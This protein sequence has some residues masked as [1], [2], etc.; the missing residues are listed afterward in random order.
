MK[1]GYDASSDDEYTFDSDDSSFDNDDGDDDNSTVAEE[2]VH[3][4]RQMATAAVLAFA[5]S[6]DAR[7]DRPCL[8]GLSQLEDRNDA[9]TSRFFEYLPK[10]LQ[11]DPVA[12]ASMVSNV[13]PHGA[14]IATV[15]YNLKHAVEQ[16]DDTRTA[17]CLT[18]IFRH[19]VLLNMPMRRFVSGPMERSL[20]LE[21]TMHI[22]PFANPAALGMHQ[23]L[24]TTLVGICVRQVGLASP[25][26]LS[27][28]VDQWK[29]YERF[30]FH[31]PH[32]A[33]ARL[34][35]IGTTLCHSRKDASVAYAR[36]VFDDNAK[37]RD[38]RAQALKH[39]DV[40]A[41]YIP[42]ADQAYQ[43]RKML[44]NN[45]VYFTNRLRLR[46]YQAVCIG[47]PHPEY[48]CQGGVMARAQVIKLMDSLK[49]SLP[50]DAGPEALSVFQ[51]AEDIMLMM[52]AHVNNLHD[53]DAYETLQVDL[54]I[55]VYLLQRVLAGVPRASLQGPDS[56]MYTSR[57]MI[58][59]A[60]RYITS[61]FVQ[62]LWNATTD[63]ADLIRYGVCADPGI[64]KFKAPKKKGVT[65]ADLLDSFKPVIVSRH[66]E[67]LPPSIVRDDNNIVRESPASA[68]QRHPGTDS[69]QFLFGMYRLAS[70]WSKTKMAFQADADRVTVDRD[71]VDLRQG[72]K[73]LY[74]DASSGILAVEATL[75][76]HAVAQIQAMVKAGGGPQAKTN[77][78]TTTSSSETSNETLHTSDVS[79]ADILVDHLCRLDD[80]DSGKM[81]KAIMT[82]PFDPKDTPRLD[83]E[84]AWYHDMKTVL[85][86]EPD[87]AF[88][89]K[90]M[91][92]DLS[93]MVEGM[94]QVLGKVFAWVVYV[95]C[96]D[97]HHKTNTVVMTIE[98]LKHM[99][100]QD[101]YLGK[102]AKA[103]L[104]P[105]R[106]VRL[107]AVMKRTCDEHCSWK[108][109]DNYVAFNVT[110]K[111]ASIVMGNIRLIC[112][113]ETLLGKYPCSG[114]LSTL[115]SIRR[116][117]GKCRTDSL[118]AGANV[119]LARCENILNQS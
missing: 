61:A 93:A 37:M 66:Q 5:T 34:L 81:V 101:P 106:L 60:P 88:S 42:D 28:V 52:G 67:S 83:K 107:L 44:L 46:R 71:F 104:R 90:L 86:V 26:A 12:L 13:S 102:I 112:S 23:R 69:L 32:E 97:V 53:R 116:I 103:I 40:V 35:A 118:Y 95:P 74:R 3:R 41:T 77:A 25:C 94:G 2:E 31:L 43:A 47:M 6:D 15:E 117:V 29:A 62:R 54:Q 64:V 51:D 33:L 19:F 84:I 92:V 17:A 22:G 109:G 115:E 80:T 18:E 27:Y 114:D 58:A 10:R 113:T 70:M 89:T 98:E 87:V 59:A 14:T 78:R 56:L 49:Q 96:I 11:A 85:G 24:F 91:M 82:G 57:A 7:D 45:K 39:A 68:M 110:A 73:T 75:R 111:N 4:Q 21:L 20:R 65:T 1:R 30:V 48:M 76:A 99:G 119:E 8:L 100:T 55:Y 38:W 50:R 16:R 9:A 72:V 108:I 105:K 79:E 63:V 36:H